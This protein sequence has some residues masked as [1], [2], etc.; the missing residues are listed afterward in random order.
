[1]VVAAERGV[2]TDCEENISI[3][4]ILSLNWGCYGPKWDI[5]TIGEQLYFVYYPII[6]YQ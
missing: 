3:N 6:S 1:M 4:D 2:G 5:W